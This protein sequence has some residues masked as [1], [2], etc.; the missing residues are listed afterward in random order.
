MG[1]PVEPDA[2]DYAVRRARMA[3]EQFPES[4]IGITVYVLSPLG[5][6][7]WY[8]LRPGWD[9]FLVLAGAGTFLA[10]ASFVLRARAWLRR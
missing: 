1:R 5:L 9:T 8:L 2:H 6:L 7:V 10:G 3:S 4:R